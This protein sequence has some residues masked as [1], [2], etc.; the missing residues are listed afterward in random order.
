MFSLTAFKL[1]HDKEC[2]G[3]MINDYSSTYVHFADNG[4]IIDKDLFSVLNN[5][6]YYSIESNYDVELTYFADRS[7]ILKKRCLGYYGH[8]SNLQAIENTVRLIGENTKCV[9]FNHLSEETNSEALATKW[10][11]KHLEIWNKL[12][13][14][15]NIK[16][17]YAKQNELVLMDNGLTHKEYRGVK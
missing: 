5:K 11:M 1:H 4:G 9:M 8:S 2:V 17:S 13:V 3:Y 15:K 10:H 14:T 6:E 16:F 7:P 12:D